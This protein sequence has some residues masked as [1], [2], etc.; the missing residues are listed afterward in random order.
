MRLLFTFITPTFIKKS[1]L[2][3]R[4]IRVEVLCEFQK[5]LQ[6]FLKTF[7]CLCSIIEMLLFWRSAVH[8]VFCQEFLI[9]NL[10]NIYYVEV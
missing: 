3:F 8:K 7:V 2:V 4:H 5:L 10:N 9:A 1:K 6:Q